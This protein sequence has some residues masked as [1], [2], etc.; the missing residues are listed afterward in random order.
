MPQVEFGLYRVASATV[1][2]DLMT[3]TTN[4]PQ[5]SAAAPTLLNLLQTQAKLPPH[6]QI[7]IAGNR[8]GKDFD[9]K[10]SM[11]RYITRP[12][13]SGAWNYVKF[14]APGEQG[15]RGGRYESRLPDEKGLEQ[16]VNRYVAEESKEKRYAN[17]SC[18][19]IVSQQ[20]TRVYSFVLKKQVTN[21]NTEYLE[22]QI[23]NLVASTGYKGKLT[24]TFP[25][26]H[27]NFVVQCPQNKAWYQA[28]AAAFQPSQA[29]RYEVVTAVWPY[30]ALSPDDASG[31]G[32][33]W[34][35]KSEM[36]F[37]AEWKD[38][39]KDAILSKRSGWLT[40]ED[41]MEFAMS[42]GWQG[43]KQTRDWD[44]NTPETNGS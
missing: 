14:I 31:Q 18:N 41:H 40:I 15:W 16:W 17:V 28:I 37:W 7:R 23:R 42:A 3:T 25:V 38:V 32:N 43:K 20:L 1:S 10:I 39:L 8:E 44:W 5:Y 29:R 4:H 35:V 36:Q 19:N 13:D 34:A 27:S 33:A 6:P 26:T 9:I 24:V 2:K 11:M 21:W 30:A 22:G 12:P